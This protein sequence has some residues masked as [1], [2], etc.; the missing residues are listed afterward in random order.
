MPSKEYCDDLLAKENDKLDDAQDALDE[1][2][3]ALDEMEQAAQETMGSGAK[4][5]GHG[6]GGD[7]SDAFADIIDMVIGNESFERA[8]EKVD[9][10]REKWEREEQQRAD[11]MAKWCEEC[12]TEPDPDLADL[13]DP[14][15]QHEVTFDEDEVE[16]IIGH[17]GG[18]GWR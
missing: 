15:G 18:R 5:G 3:E 14:D 13:T 10:A 11:A 8:S 4:A 9:R 7:W 17:P 16:P 2:N 6:L 1:Y 12:G